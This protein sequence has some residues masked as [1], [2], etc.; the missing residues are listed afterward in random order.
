MAGQGRFCLNLFFFLMSGIGWWMFAAECCAETLEQAWAEATA[1]SHKLQAQR[2]QIQANRN[3]AQ[4]A[5]ALRTPIISN[6][7]AVVAMAEV[8]KM[9]NDVS[10]TLPP[11]FSILQPFVPPITAETNLTDRTFVANSTIAA[12]PLYTG[13]K[14]RSAIHAANAQ[15]NA[16][17]AGYAVASQDVKMEVA[18]M[19]FMVLR[20]RRL[21]EVAVQAEN[22]I[23]AH[24]RNSQKMLET[25]LVTRNVVLA[26]QT[27][28]SAAAQDVL[29]AE[30]AV[31]TVEAAYNRLLNR[32]LNAAVELEEIEI[33]PPLSEQPEILN[34]A[35]ANR[36]ELTQLQSQSQAFREQSKM[37]RADRLPQVV[38]G[39]SITYMGNSNIDPNTF[40]AGGVGVSWTP[41]DGGGSRARQ[42]AAIHG[43]MAVNQMRE[44]TRSLIDLQIQTA[45][46]SEQESRSRIQVAV[47][48]VK[49]SEENLRVVTMQ[50]QSGLVN[51]TE[52]L[53]AQS[54]ASSARA[55]Y[56]NAVYDA[57]LA[58]F[59]LKRAIGVF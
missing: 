4:A 41:F 59:R 58:T 27:A 35:S 39:G 47:N 45:I 55:N 54:L 3:A 37:A 42:R 28:K 49:L 53:D 23:A 20:T 16:S 29:R 8:P 31:K 2:Y 12:V 50:F 10:I 9:T 17:V 57:I 43:A 46:L 30:N 24:E 11:P 33:P 36:S 1:N 48:G 26:A 5:N 25:H 40:F 15:V 34:M 7:T 18:E 19:Y 6:Q 38:A 13:G 32:P 56:Y 22:A 44:E 52:V 14:I 21:Y 51:H